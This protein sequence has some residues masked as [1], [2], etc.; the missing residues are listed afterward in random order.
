MWKSLR[1]ST[2]SGE[3]PGVSTGIVTSR[4]TKALRS[5]RDA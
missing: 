4:M 3:D 1:C 2:R 5:I